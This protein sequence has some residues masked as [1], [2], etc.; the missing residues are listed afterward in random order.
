ME[1]SRERDFFICPHCGTRVPVSATSCREC[2]SD[3]ETGWSES[4]GEW[5]ENVPSAGYGSDDDFD[6]EEF[7]VNEFPDQAPASSRRRAWT[8]VVSIVILAFLIWALT[9]L[10]SV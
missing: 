6:H 8:I 4:A 2:G 10:R 7:V 1:R 9:Q 3:D 5:E